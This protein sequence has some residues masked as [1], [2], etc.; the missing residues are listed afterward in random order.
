MSSVT[1]LVDYFVEHKQKNCTGHS[2]N[3]VMALSATVSALKPK[4]DIWDENDGCKVVKCVVEYNTEVE[5]PEDVS[6]WLGTFSSL[7]LVQPGGMRDKETVVFAY[8]GRHMDLEN[9][10]NLLVPRLMEYIGKFET[11]AR[12]RTLNLTVQRQDESERPSYPDL[13]NKHL[14]GFA[15]YSYCCNHLD[16]VPIWSDRF[17]DPNALA[18]MI[19]SHSQRTTANN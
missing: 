8:H 9:V 15:V 16:L 7:C 12:N 11:V 6:K 13:F 18:T 4:L 1:D 10:G 3:M 5:L 17:L 2:C 19:Y 14:V